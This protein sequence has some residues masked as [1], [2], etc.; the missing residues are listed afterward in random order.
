MK[1]V[2]VYFLFYFDGLLSCCFLH[3]STVI[4]LMWLTCV[5]KPLLPSA[6]EVCSGHRVLFGILHPFVLDFFFLDPAVTC[7]S[8]FFPFGLK[9]AVSILFTLFFS[10]R[11]VLIGLSSP[12]LW[13]HRWSPP[14]CHCYVWHRAALEQTML[15]HPDGNLNASFECEVCVPWGRSGD[16]S[17]ECHIEILL[18]PQTE[19][20]EVINAPSCFRHKC[21]HRSRQHVRHH[22]TPMR[23]HDGSSFFPLIFP[24][25]WF[26]FSSQYTKDL[27]TNWLKISCNLEGGSSG[28]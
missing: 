16:G 4:R 27:C 25:L 3:L 6:F 14:T 17:P 7:K 24:S 12:V 22:L 19:R 9:P 10:R 28:C 26:C 2:P 20:R 18:P 21:S 1:L 23:F 13:M 11:M 8:A 15:V 5:A